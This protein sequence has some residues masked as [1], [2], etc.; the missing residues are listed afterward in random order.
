M[1]SGWKK[2]VRTENGTWSHE[3]LSGILEGGSRVIGPFSGW[4]F[5][6]Q[7]RGF[8]L[9]PVRP[10]SVRAIEDLNLTVSFVA[11]K[12]TARWWQCSVFIFLL[13]KPGQGHLYFSYQSRDT[14]AML[15]P[16][17][18]PHSHSVHLPLQSSHSCG[19]ISKHKR[20]LLSTSPSTW[21]SHTGL[22]SF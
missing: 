2:K 10:I 14:H 1:R 3:E 4:P 8:Q 9:D 13:G 5:R 20:T 15:S 22:L 12:Y 19:P 11:T 6:I 16:L 17:A 21:S 18:L 7:L